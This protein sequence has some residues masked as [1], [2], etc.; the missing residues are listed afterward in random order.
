MIVTVTACG[1]GGQPGGTLL[2][3]SGSTTAG[4]TPASPPSS[5]GT[6]ASSRPGD[7]SPAAPA[8]LLAVGD[9]AT[10]DGS[11][12]EAVAR[13]TAATAGTVALL[14]DVAYPD[15]SE[16]DYRDC[17]L[18]AW[19]ELTSRLWPVPGNH[20][21]ETA[22]AAP[23]FAYFGARAAT[24][25]QGWYAYDLGSWRIYALNSNC[26]AIGGCGVG[27][28]QL[29]W[30]AVDLADHP[31]QCSLAYWHHPRFSS[32][33]H[34]DAPFMRDAWAMLEAAGTD[35]VLAGHDH[36]YERFA[37]LDADGTPSPDGIRSFVVGTG[38]KSHYN[39]E[40][41]R[42]GSEVRD[43]EHF[44]ILRIDLADGGYAWRF[45]ATGTAAEIDSGQAACRPAGP[46]R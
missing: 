3:S 4:A 12:D 31:R 11:Q 24:P 18:P 5:S 15:G 8:V 17:F 9:I 35:V 7:P 14:G 36:T 44:G 32:G 34:G 39:F 41:L 6:P 1:I 40:R 26:D 22:G 37:P 43:N 10:C 42:A 21:Y 2:G 30:L 19:G 25:G 46:R 20:E 27:S 29:T 13:L 28:S 23:Y 45:L 38:G 33:R 16:A